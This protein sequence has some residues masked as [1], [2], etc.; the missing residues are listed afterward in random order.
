MQDLL[1][2]SN[3]L[4]QGGAARVLMDVTVPLEG[5]KEACKIAEVVPLLVFL[6]KDLNDEVRAN[7]AGALMTIA[8]T[9]EG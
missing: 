1:Q 6:L 8:I 5:K 7:A 2:H 3:Y 4:V 9:T